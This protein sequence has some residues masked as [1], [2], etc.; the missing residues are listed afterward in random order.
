MG[1]V[2]RRA[3]FAEHIRSGAPATGTFLKTPAHQTVELIAQTGLDFAVLDA[4]HAPFDPSQVDVCMLASQAGDLPLLVRVPRNAPDTILG[5]LDMGATGIFVPHVAT[6]D[7]AQ[8]ASAA[9]HYIGGERGFSPS[10]RAGGYGT[11]GLRPY[12]EAADREV[13]LILQIEDAAALDH[14][15][16]IASTV[17]V[18]GLF[19]GRADLA[20]SLQ[21]D[22]NDPR[23]DE[24]TIAVASACA[25]AGIAAGA[26]LSDPS[27]LAAFQQWGV[28]FFV[29]G[30]DQSAMKTELSRVASAFRTPATTQDQAA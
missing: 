1:R 6:P 17:G 14:L 5:A 24:A 30:S 20:A 27:R 7:D 22:W 8:R 3:S 19:V 21:L 13:C 28:S 11:R 29:V 25:R 9:C 26:Y 15:D 4:E 18:A 10:T 2:S 16:A 23:L 12:M